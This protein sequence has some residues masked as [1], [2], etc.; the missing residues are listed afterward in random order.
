MKRSEMRNLGL[1]ELL[2]M[3]IPSGQIIITG[4][5]SFTERA[6]ADAGKVMRIFAMRYRLPDDD[7]ELRRVWALPRSA[8][9]VALD[10]LLNCRY[11]HEVMG[12]KLFEHT[13]EI[14]AGTKMADTGKYVEEYYELT[15]KRFID[16][17][18]DG[19]SAV[20]VEDLRSDSVIAA[21]CRRIWGHENGLLL[22]TR[23]GII[24]VP[25]THPHWKEFDAGAADLAPH[26]D[27][28]RWL[29]VVASP[30]GVR[31]HLG[32]AGNCEEA[33]KL[34]AGDPHDP[35]YTEEQLVELRQR[36][37]ADLNLAMLSFTWGTI[38]R[39]DK[40]T[41]VFPAGDHFNMFLEAV[42]SM[43]RDDRL[44]VVHPTDHKK[45]LVHRHILTTYR[46]NPICRHYHQGIGLPSVL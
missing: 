45:C 29:S 44:C 42:A 15:Q 12:V 3:P 2:A 38:W 22:C 35:K 6:G 5:V 27:I 31:F 41:D 23:A 8:N 18:N 19:K 4:V 33:T 37:E 46:L 28:D 1:R 43:P 30:H 39:I 11:G 24:N 21:S 17:M 34:L 13:V 32:T 20:A 36:A 40:N 25:N 9:D 10:T 26:L 7:E 16:A 14:P